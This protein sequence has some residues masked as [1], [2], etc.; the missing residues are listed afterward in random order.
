MVDETGPRAMPVPSGR[1]ARLARLG[2]LGAGV[3]GGAAARG[4]AELGRGRRPG[5]R[6]L[7]ITP[8]NARR[9]AAELAR[10][11]GAAMKLG[12]LVSMDAGDMLPP[13][14]AEI[15]A[16]LREGAHVMPP[17]QLGQVLNAEW[18][19]G[20]RGRFERFDV[21][22]VASASIGQVH[23]AR[24]RDGREL[25]IKVQYPG[26]ARSIDADV[27]N[28]G[29]LMRMSGLLPAGFELAP[30]LEAAR[31]QLHEETDYRAEAA[32]M[33]RFAA[34]LAGDDR[35]VLPAPQ[36]DWSTGQVLAMTWVEG[37]PIEEAAAA[38][39]AARDRIA[40]DLVDL[41]LAE[42]FDMGW[43]QTDPNFANYRWQPGTG[44]I[45]LLDFGAVRRIDA[46][47]SD[48][49]RR[50]LAAGLSGE[51]GATWD[52]ARAL[53]LLPPDMAPAHA[54]RVA[55]IMEAAFAALREDPFDF[56][57]SDLPERM[58]DEGILLAEAGFV[59]PPPPIEA[60]YVQ[61]KLAGTF[62]LGARLR[63]RVRVGAGGGALPGP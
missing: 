2:A 22:P 42:L 59:P 18:P 27:A 20:W 48:G 9:V 63:A 6:D 15:M 33:A 7:L 21:R 17:A 43:M 53:G 61:R 14:L 34:L 10:M 57:A 4:L 55:R 31:A 23:R 5:V 26:V 50:L 36:P 47:A 28:V 37:R 46:A 52:A 58:R 30:Y 51:G 3:A 62:L 13:E 60:L 45:A 54:A 16:Q 29:A 8:A 12:Q 56:A 25:A 40:R 38:P 41:V 44:R 32:H 1:L 49:F 35:F 24:L 11:R 39:Q 19:A